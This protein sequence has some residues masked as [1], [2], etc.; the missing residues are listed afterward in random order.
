MA[1]KAAAAAGVEVAE[2]PAAKMGEA[3][4]KQCLL[5]TPA[6]GRG[7]RVLLN[8]LRSFLFF[9]AESTPMDTY[10]H[11][12]DTMLVGGG[13]YLRSLFSPP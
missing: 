6:A 7:G 12:H 2:M 5:L 3:A 11:F 1:R 8:C 4:G 13:M 10:G 9:P